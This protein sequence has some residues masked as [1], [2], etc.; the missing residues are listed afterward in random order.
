MRRWNGWGDSNTVYPIPDEGRT[1]LADQIGRG[2]TIADAPYEGLLSAVPSS[3]L[4]PDTLVTP[5]PAVRL[6][7]AHGQSLPDWIA[8][9]HGRLNCFPDGVA[10][11]ESEDQIRALLDIARARRFA[12]I[13]YGGGTSVVGHVNPISGDRPVV[14]V[15]LTRMNRL[16]DVDERS[17]LATIEAGATG[18]EVESQLAARGYTLGHFPQSFEA[19]T[20][21]G[22]IATRSTG[23]QSLHY[24]RI[25]GLFAGGHLETPAGP[26]DLPVFPASAA[27]PDLR[28]LVLG[29]EGRLGLVT[30]ATVRVR[31]VPQ[32][33]RFYAF[34]FRSWE[35]G[36]EAVRR[37][38]QD[39]PT[40]SM[41]RLSDP[42]E[43][44]TSLWLAGRPG[45]V[46]WARRGL[47]WA[48]YG[49]ARCLLIAAHTG[50]RAPVVRG[51]RVGGLPVGRPI[52]EL[53]RR[54]RF[55]T[56][57]LRNSLWEAGYALDTFETAVPWSQF[58]A[59][60]NAAIGA[61]STALEDENE[62]VLAFAHLSHGYPDGASVYVTAVFRRT[63]DP[64]QTLERW[65]RLKTAAT[66]AFVRCGGTVSHQHGVGRD[67]AGYLPEEKGRLGIESLAAAF[68]VFDPDGL[69]NPGKLL[70]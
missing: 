41:L 16:L 14:T 40:V 29:S 36:V 46:R 12:L 69:M 31:R 21:G 45:L 18:P 48:G 1:F 19:S 39:F 68:R 65:K 4:E 51:S 53:W 23:Q 57:Y 43:T 15:A 11:P 59:C 66:D 47:S 58:R 61:L 8:L 35:E 25:E 27:G 32:D 37:T 3:R 52:G 50:E 70:G 55:R 60:R 10:V 5:D 24:G 44:E 56:P 34:F 38:A 9:R 13:P 26:F 33:E 28:H 54:S 67:H 63:P 49:R 2:A 17:R 64:D 22:W 42:V 30:R 7:H 6:A 20:L 62:R